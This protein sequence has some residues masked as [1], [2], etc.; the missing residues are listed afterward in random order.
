MQKE[1][2]LQGALVLTLAGIAVKV[3]GAGNR[4]LLSRLL[5]GEGIGL[6]QMAYPLYLLA[7]TIS[8]A[9][10]PTAISILVAEQAAHHNWPAVRKIFRLSML[11]MLVS[12]V[13]FSGGLW[14]MA[15]WLIVEQW[16]RDERAYYAIIALAPAIFFVTLSAGYRG[17]FQG[18]Q[19]MQPTAVSQIIEQL[20][21]VA[22]MLG[23]AFWLL[24][25]GLALAAAGASFGAAPGA[26]C[27]LLFLHYVYWRQRPSRR[28]QL[29]GG[30]QAT[31]ASSGAILRRLL[32]LAL[33][34]S[35]ANLMVPLVANL[36]LLIVPG[37]LEAAGYSVT[38]A[39][40]LF[41]YLTG[42]AVVLIALPTI[43]P[44]SLAASLVPAIAEDAAAGQWPT[45]RRRVNI[46]LRITVFCTIP[47]AIGLYCLAT[48]ISEM[49]YGTVSA[50]ST[51]EILSLGV[52]LLGLHQV[53][54][55]VLHGLGCTGI[56]LIN[57]AVSA[58]VKVV[59]NWMLTA[60]P[61]LGIHGAAWATNVDFGIAALLNLYFVR[62]YLQSRFPL[63]AALR[64]LAAAAGMGVV[65]LWFYDFLL[66]RTTSNTAATLAAIGGGVGVY[67]ILLIVCGAVR[68]DEVRQI[69][70]IGSRLEKW[71]R[72]AGW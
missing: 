63:G 70:H 24:P 20:I 61:E 47:S 31:V 45:A 19:Y 51:I 39:T 66:F 32:R 30:S 69:P 23:L 43:L 10:I 52:V 8:A 67:G 48:P 56:P 68:R 33:P 1:R 38:Q 41:G 54:T 29:R 57:M 44:S 37:R 53:T 71:L 13:L 65:V 25:H 6:Y 40:E 4:I 5:G 2:F 72:Y 21:R 15:D 28:L 7:I 35:L 64:S 9:G 11:A 22:T 46:A 12:G 50:G 14:L 62:Q 27:A 3:V 59:L 18:L 34:V 55:G 58:L 49:L 16:V 36:D 26:C 60:R 17:Y 42:M